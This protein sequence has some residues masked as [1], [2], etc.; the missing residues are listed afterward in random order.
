MTYSYIRQIPNISKLVEQQRNILAFS[1]SNQI[2]IDKEVIEYATKKLPINDR[3][4]FNDFLDNMKKGD[5]V[6][7]YNLS[8]LSDKVEEIIKI[9]N[10]MLSHK[11]NLW[12]AQSQTLLNSKTKMTQI[13]PLLNNLREEQK[14]KTSTVGR[15]KGSKSTSKFDIYQ[16]EIISLLQAKRSVTAI[17]KE[18]NVSRSS[19]KDYIESRELKSLAFN[20]WL[21]VNERLKGVENILLICP[22]EQERKKQKEI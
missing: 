15:P 22:F 19:L 11:V 20:N 6:V 18:L 21:E 4:K 14:E 8:M 5:T 3:K 12:I 13:C 7:V 9:L 16:G 10:C 2:E 17:A 1:L